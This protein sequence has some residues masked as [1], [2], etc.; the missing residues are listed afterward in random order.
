MKFGIQPSVC[1]ELLPV[2]CLH[3]LLGQR[4]DQKLAT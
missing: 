3:W 1:Q 4:T 2:N